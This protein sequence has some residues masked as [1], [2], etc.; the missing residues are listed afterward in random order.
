MLLMPNEPSILIIAAT[1]REIRAFRELVSVPAPDT[2]PRI[3]CRGSAAGAGSRH[4]RLAIS[5]IG[6]SNAAMHTL[7]LLHQEPASLVIDTGCAGAYPESDLRLGDVTLSSASV[8]AD[9][10]VDIGSEFADLQAMGLAIARD[11]KGQELYNEMPTFLDPTWLPM[12]SLDFRVHSGIIATTST[13]SGTRETARL[14][15]RGAL[16]EAMEGAAVALAANE[17]GCPF[18]EVR[19]ISNEA[20]DRDHSRW[21]IDLACK[22]AARVV[23]HIINQLEAPA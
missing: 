18:V 17:T 13:C 12:P 21:D 23:A 19:G 15:A 4:L 3:V 1:Q 22:N 11:P 20:G 2:D 14:R 7:D 8:F 16:A 10:G 6:K 9:E 5:G